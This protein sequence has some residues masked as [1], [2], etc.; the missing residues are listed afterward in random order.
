MRVNH[1]ERSIDGNGR[2]NGATTAT[3]DVIAGSGG[4]IVRGANHTAFGENRWSA[5]SWSI[6]VNHIKPF[7]LFLKADD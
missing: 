7:I 4:Q 1:T 3:Q 2:I 6:S 5:G